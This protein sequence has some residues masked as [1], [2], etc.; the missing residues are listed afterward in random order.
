MKDVSGIPIGFVA[1]T[2]DISEQKRAEEERVALEQKAQ[3][4]SRLAS[5]GE[6]AAGIAHEINNPLTGVIGFAHLL[7]QREI[8]EDMRNEVKIIGDSA[9]RVA[10][11]VQRLLIFAHPQVGKRESIDIKQLIETTLALRAYELKTNN[12]K[13]TTV[14]DPEL[15]WIMADGGQLQQVFL[16]LVINAET[17]MK[18]AHGK[19][20]LLIKAEMAG[21]IVRVSF[22]DDGPGIAKANMA[23]LFDPFFTTREIGQG[24]GLGLSVCHGIIREHNG[25]IYVESKLGEGATFVVE[26]PSAVEEKQ[27]GLVELA[28][29]EPE[30][31]KG[32][33]LVVDDEPM[34]R[35]FLTKLLVGKGHEV[36]SID[37]ASDALTKIKNERYSVI[38]LDIKMPGMSGIELYQ[39]VQ[40]I[41]KSLARRIIFMTG[42]VMG[43]DT[44]DFLSKTGAHYVAKPISV[45]ELVK[46]INK[47]LD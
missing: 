24:T 5:V 32:R 23:K 37:N 38:L 21:N 22:H 39:R 13:V 8:P 9:Q 47:V 26:I 3:V 7:S 6:M 31:T 30:V 29:E 16:N 14:L 41:A 10:D 35:E 27:R 25:R 18:L 36:D 4:A 33:I 17:E 44:R 19:G 2:E 40:Q 42:D 15:P 11:I 12:I 45:D 20:K 46:T 1:I 43:I 28:V 34:V